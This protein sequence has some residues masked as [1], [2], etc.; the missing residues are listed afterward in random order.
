MSRQVDVT[1]LITFFEE[2]QC[3]DTVKFIQF[4]ASPDAVGLMET[5]SGSV[6]LDGALDDPNLSESERLH[7]LMFKTYAIY[8][9][10]KDGSVTPLEWMELL[11]ESF[12]KIESKRQAR[13]D[14]AFGEMLAMRTA[15]VVGEVTIVDEHGVRHVSAEEAMKERAEARAHTRKNAIN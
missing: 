12:D 3:Q 14:K 5:G 9:G 4:L 15:P 11:T 2:R 6:D 7:A 1:R 8:V 13:L 10:S